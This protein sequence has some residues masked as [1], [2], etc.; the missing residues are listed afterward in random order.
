MKL[1]LELI[2]DIILYKINYGVQLPDGVYDIEIKNTKVITF[3]ELFGGKKIPEREAEEYITIYFE[4][5]IVSSLPGA[6]DHL[7][8]HKMRDDTT[9]P[10]S[11]YTCLLRQKKLKDIGV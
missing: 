4:S 1:D 7:K 3:S 6:V 11:E 5:S 2:R 8:N 10:M 9:I